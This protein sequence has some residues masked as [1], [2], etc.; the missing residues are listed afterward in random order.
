MNREPLEALARRVES[1]PFFLGSVLADYQRRHG[2]DEP[3][4]AALL[5]CPVAALASVRL[6]RRPGAA[7][8]HRTA[9]QDIEDICRRFGC[10]RAALRR[11]VREGTTGTH[12]S[13]GSVNAAGTD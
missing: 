4:L 2:L 10:D 12:S 5:N 6:C 3:A 9:G 11:I 1:D 13:G 7:E 8:P